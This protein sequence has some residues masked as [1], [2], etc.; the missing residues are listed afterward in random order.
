MLRKFS[1]NALKSS[2]L[3]S[4]VNVFPNFHVSSKRNTWIAQS[5]S[6]GFFVFPLKIVIQQNT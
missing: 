1:V 5:K 4:E 2:S 6:A 3:C